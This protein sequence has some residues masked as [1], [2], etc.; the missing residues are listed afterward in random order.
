MNGRPLEGILH[1]RSTM[2]HELPMDDGPLTD[3]LTRSETVTAI[4]KLVLGLF[5]F[6]G[7]IAILSAYFR[8]PIEHLGQV[9]VTRF[10]AP[11]MALGAFLADGAH[12]PLPPQFY[13]L[14]GEAGGLGRAASIGSVLT[15]SI[16]GG[17]VAFTFGRKLASS[18]FVT[19]RIRAPKALVARMFE[20]H[21]YV[22]IALA[23]MLP[24]SFWVICTLGGALRLPFRAYAVI[25]LVRVPRLL[26]SY[27]IVALAWRHPTPPHAPTSARD[28]AASLHTVAAAR[29]IHVHPCHAHCDRVA[30][31]QPEACS[32]VDDLRARLPA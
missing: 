17:L 24:I 4:V 14:A 8:A 9:F 11:G 21:G 3:E 27:A 29:R 12:F 32:F 26:V 15:G 1:R 2:A 20:R 18:P 13:L 23:G 5:A 19:K 28:D 16:L 10:G 6:L 22:G 7:L 31:L 25:A 30:K